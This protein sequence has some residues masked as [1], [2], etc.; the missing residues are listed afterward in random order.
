M[1]SSRPHQTLYSLIYFFLFA[2]VAALNPFFPLLLQSK[3]YTPSAIGVLMGSYE[4]FSIMGLLLIGHFYDRIKSPRRTV[5]VIFLFCILIL[6]LVAGTGIPVILVPLTL[7]LG[8]FIK[9]PASLV[10]AHYGQIMPE[11]QKTYGKARLFGSLGFFV[12]AMTIQLTHFVEGS[13]PFSVFAGFTAMVIIAIIL[14]ISLPPA[15]LH[16]EKHEAVSFLNT[17][18]SFPG[19]YWLGLSIAFLNFMGLSGHYTFFSLLIKNR[20]GTDDIGGFWAIGPFF[21]IPL[22]FFSGWLLQK[23]GLKGLWIICLA[24]GAIRMQ[25]Y[26]LSDTLLPLYLVQVLHSFSFGLN[27]LAMVTLISKTTS[28]ASR[29]MAMSIYSAVGMGFSQF[30]G[31]FLGAWILGFTGFPHLFQIYSLF[32]LAGMGLTILFLK[33][34]HIFR[35]QGSF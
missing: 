9:S 11:P 6:F 17:V 30:V 1:T 18:K 8:F 16:E 12:M 2:G 10:D 31:G 24:A 7:S 33:T 22:F 21:E 32:P 28:S 29:G 25:V 19:L 34:D 13:R 23:I 20:F 5:V 3:G 4:L 14:I 26:S 15:A 35:E 27:H